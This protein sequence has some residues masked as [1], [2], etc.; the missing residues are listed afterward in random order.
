MPA[1]MADEVFA[2]VGYVLCDFGE[3]IEA[4][5]IA[6]GDRLAGRHW[7]ARGSDGSGLVPRGRRRSLGRSTPDG[8][9]VRPLLRRYCRCE[10][11]RS[12]A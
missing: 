7:R 5:E 10:A 6:L 1:V 3:E 8:F 2:F 4:A 11:R 9:A 12:Y